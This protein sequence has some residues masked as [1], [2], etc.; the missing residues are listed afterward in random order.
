[1]PNKPGTP[2]NTSIILNEQELKFITHYQLSKSEAIHK[3]M[4]AMMSIIESIRSTHGAEVARIA[5]QVGATGIEDFGEG[6]EGEMHCTFFSLTGQ[7]AN[8]PIRGATTNASPV[9][10]DEDSQAF[11][12]LAEACGVEI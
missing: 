12:E 2:P 8:F 11:G 9:W 7:G 10:E 1:M 3:A 5:A 4:E 6:G